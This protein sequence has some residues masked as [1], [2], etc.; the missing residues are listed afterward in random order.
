[1]LVLAVATVILSGARAQTPSEED[2]ARTARTLAQQL[3]ELGRADDKAQLA[4]KRKDLAA[5][6]ALCV[7]GEGFTEQHFVRAGFPFLGG[8]WQAAL[9]IS[10]AGTARFPESR[11]LHDH[12]GYARITGA[13]A[14]PPSAA[15]VAGLG[16]AEAAFRKALQC[17][18]D[19]WHA[20]AGLYQV[21]EHLGYCDEALRELDK[22]LQHA[23]AG[24][25]INL[26]WLRRTG[27]LMRCERAKEALAVLKAVTP[28]DDEKVDV[29][30]MLLRAT[31]LCGDA[32]AT[33]AAANALRAL[34]SSPRTLVEAADALAYAGKTDEA[35]KLLAQR[36]KHG[37][38]ESEEE[39]E[40]Q[41]YS[42][43]AEAMEAFLKATD[44]SPGGPL[45]AAL[46][47]AL[48]HH[49]FLMGAG[50]RQDDLAGSPV[51][52]TKLLGDS[53]MA[54]EPIKDWG[55]HVLFVLSMRAVP[56]H[57][58]TPA[59]Q[60]LVAMMKQ[61]RWPTADDIPGRLLALRAAVGEPDQVGALTALRAVEKLDPKTPPTPA[62]K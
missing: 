24:A 62:K 39:R 59:E 15:R 38:F 60:Q 9:A 43:S 57:E 47:K 20:H 61:Q 27:L 7:K 51:M 28:E 34:E 42:Q 32:A 18:P 17:K 14:E 8:E 44:F 37:K 25:T 1:L 2:V 29:Q 46:T 21:L 19:T 11:F 13:F 16:A 6:V 3:G 41:L 49:F 5:F 10:E 12:V 48:D 50:G 22:A 54:E 35:L 56:A 58:P 4:A 40:A 55:N 45:R 36:P 52:M 23:E 53:G 31:A 30:I 33:Q 26:T